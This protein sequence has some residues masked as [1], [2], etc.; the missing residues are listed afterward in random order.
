MHYL[1]FFILFFL[2]AM[3]SNPALS[4][5]F[6]LNN[7]LIPG[8]AVLL[9]VSGFPK[10]SVLTGDINNKKFPISKDGLAMI[11]LDMGTKEGYA[12]VRI[13]IAPKTGRKE[14]ISRKFWISPR[15]Y[16]EERIELPKKKVSPVKKDMSKA[17]KET[18]AI[19]ATYKLRGDKV[20][21]LGEFRQA[22][23]G[24]FSGIFGSR[25]ILNGKPKK[26]HSGVDIAAP[27]GTPIVTTAPGTVVL[28]GK[29]YFFTGNTIVIHHGDGV[30]SLY[31]HMDSMLVEEGEWLPADTIIGTIG[32]TG[33]A[34]G[35]HL[36][37]ATMVRGARVD[38]M[39]M[40]GIR[41][42]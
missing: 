5:S 6:K 8:S 9:Q 17:M 13:K 11:A 42:P 36:H 32:M 34:T 16:K 2:T 28:T 35:P 3:F 10:G 12:S 19:K 14:T 21:Y 23:E 31:A 26:A 24:R 40:P 22:V 25:R 39:L 15:K 18:R 30:I 4:A 41:K 1:G 7:K 27:K 37:W 33:R 20:G 29:D 38:P